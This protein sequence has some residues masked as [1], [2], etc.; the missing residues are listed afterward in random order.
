MKRSPVEAQMDK[1]KQFLIK[2]CRENTEKFAVP[3][4]TI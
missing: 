1:N 4:D 2:I 3:F